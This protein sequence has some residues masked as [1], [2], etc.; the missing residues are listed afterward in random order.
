MH[1]SVRWQNGMGSGQR[2]NAVLLKVGNTTPWCALEQFREAI[3]ASG[4]I[5]PLNKNTRWWKNTEETKIL[6]SCSCF[7]WCEHRFKIN[8]QNVRHTYLTKSAEILWKYSLY[9]NCK[10]QCVLS[11]TYFLTM[12]LNVD[13]NI[14]KLSNANFSLYLS[15]WRKKIA[16]GD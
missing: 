4:A 16:E 3:V 8:I 13:Q 14:H 6:E 10:L 5:R 9:Y 12:F 11:A 15:I 7:M 1:T 2:F